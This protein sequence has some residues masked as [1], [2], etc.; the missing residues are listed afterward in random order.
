MQL[1]D[2]TTR[3]MWLGKQ[4]SVYSEILERMDKDAVVRGMSE[5]EIIWL[6]HSHL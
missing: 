6:V 4:L 3:A 2:H 1:G 5:E